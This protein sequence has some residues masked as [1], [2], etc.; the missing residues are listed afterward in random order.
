M[1][2]IRI[3]SRFLGVTSVCVAAGGLVVAGPVVFWPG[4]LQDIDPL[5]WPHPLAGPRWNGISREKGLPASWSPMKGENLIWKS[6]EL[7]TRSTPIVMRG[8]LYVLCRLNPDTITEGEKVVCVDAA[9]GEKVWENSFNMVFLTDA[10]AERVGWSCVCG[11]PVTGNVYALGLCDYFQ[12]LDGQTGKSL[13]SHSMS[14]EYGMISTYG[15]RTNMPLVF[16]D[17]VI[18]SG[19]MTGWGEYAVPAHRFVAFDK[20]NGQAVWISS[21]R[22]R[23]LDTTYSS[24]VLANFNGQ[25]AIVFGSGDGSVY[26]M[27]PRTGKILWTYD[28]S[29]RGINTTPTVVGTTVYCGHSEENVFDTTVVGALFAI[30]GSGTGNIRQDQLAVAQTDRHGGPRL[31]LRCSS[32]AGCTSSFK[33]RLSCRSAIPRPGTKSASKSWARAKSFPAP[34]MPTARSIVRSARALRRSS[35]PPRKGSRLPCSGS[36]EI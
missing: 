9:T 16:D 1:I 33:Q 30:D 4:H 2:G 21:T 32:T 10:P 22:L 35:N 6:A 14:E 11:D 26:A 25:M 5:D 24:P 12:C 19:V 23:P 36:K 7:G 3:V 27:Q 28:A 34:S 13:W 20:T 18:I 31:T 8:K 29:G 15:G 17:L